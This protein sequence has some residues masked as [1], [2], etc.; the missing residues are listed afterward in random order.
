MNAVFIVLVTVSIVLICITS[1]ESVISAMLD[2][3]ASAIS[4]VIKLLAIYTLWLSVLKMMEKNRT[5]R[6]NRCALFVRIEQ[7]F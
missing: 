1:P 2:G 5:K 6:K 7:A 4:L 3:G